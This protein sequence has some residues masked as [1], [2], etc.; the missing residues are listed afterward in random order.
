MFPGLLSDLAC[1]GDLVFPS[2]ILQVK[3]SV[4][5]DSTTP[6][7]AA[8]QASLSIAESDTTERLNRMELDAGASQVALGKEPIYQCRRHER[9]GFNPWVR[10]IPW[11]RAW[12]PTP[13]F[14]PGES[15]GQRA[16][17]AIWSIRLQGV[18][19]DFAHKHAP[20]WMLRPYLWV[21]LGGLFTHRPRECMQ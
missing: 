8:C 5:S 6:W 13:V 14:L 2:W 19:H 10:K 20:N 18:R 16:G 3:S 21:A 7:T 4:L 11:R 9:R 12:Q 17:R 1:H 15:H